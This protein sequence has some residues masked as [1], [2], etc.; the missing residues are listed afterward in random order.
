MLM[1]LLLANK[2]V[3]LKFLLSA[4]KLGNCNTMRPMHSQRSSKVATCTEKDSN[5]LKLI[6]NANL[7]E[8]LKK[9]DSTLG[10]H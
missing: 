4:M 7:S 5:H 6:L 1:N 2:L 8:R 3:N 10:Y 9:I